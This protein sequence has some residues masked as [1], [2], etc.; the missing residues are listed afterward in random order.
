MLKKQ[1]IWLLTMVS[2][3]VVLSVYYIVT[4]EM[5]AGNFS[6]IQNGDEQPVSQEKVE[7]EATSEE[8]A[9]GTDKT[10]LDAFTDLRMQLEDTRSKAKEE[11]E[12]VVAN[13]SASAEEKSQALDDM[14][15]MSQISEKEA[16]L[17]TLLKTEANIYDAFVQTSDNQIKITIAAKESNPA[18]ADQVIQMA[19]SEL[20][21]QPIAVEIKEVQS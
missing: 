7:E 10:A 19:Y 3:V 12:A 8:Q 15:E 1:T 18:L 11:L 9:T 6:L 21:K 20:G 17:E 4:P 5:Q 16:I 2:L 14:A 13:G